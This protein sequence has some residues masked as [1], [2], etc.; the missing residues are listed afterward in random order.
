MKFETFQSNCKY[1]KYGLKEDA[2]REFELTC[3]NPE[4]IPKDHSWG[5]CNELHCPHFGATVNGGVMV[6]EETGK[7]LLTFG[8]GKL[9]FGN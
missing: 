4:C 1:A 9:V 2:V 3:R 8:S 7:V 5:I 6:D